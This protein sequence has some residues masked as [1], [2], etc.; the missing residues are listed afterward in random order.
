MMS[1]KRIRLAIGLAF[2]LVV[3]AMGLTLDFGSQADNRMSAVCTAM[4]GPVGELQM[5]RWDNGLTA[6]GANW[7]SVLSNGVQEAREA[8]RDEIAAAVRQDAAGFDRF[9]ELASPELRPAL[10]RQRALAL[11]AEKGFAHRGDPQ[12]AADA[13]QIGRYGLTECGFAP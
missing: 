4:D 12:V 10:K 6:S 9:Y 5:F 11:D 8:D 13:L 2:V 1:S 3:I 7:Q